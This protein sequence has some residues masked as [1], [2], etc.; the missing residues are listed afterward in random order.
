LSSVYLNYPGKHRPPM[1]T[2]LLGIRYNY[3]QFHSHR[4]PFPPSLVDS[5]FSLYDVS[6]DAPARPLVGRAVVRLR[7]LELED[8]PCVADLIGDSFRIGSAFGS[9][10]RPLFK[11]GLREDLRSR[12]QDRD[13]QK[14]L[15]LVACLS[16][17]PYP[18]I[19]TV[20]VSTRDLSSAQGGTKRYAY[21]ANL[22]VDRE[23]RCLGIGQQLVQ[24]CAA[25]AQSWG[26]HY[27]YLHVM[28]NNGAANRLYYRLGFESVSS[29]RPWHWLPWKRETR[30]FL[31]KPLA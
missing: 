7:P 23:Y 27:T 4:P 5:S 2:D 28:A 24:Q 21:I 31:R 25:V 22:A 29:D 20:E 15:C 19:G 26:F 10:L 16:H 1:P 6:F 9:W 14:S 11:L 3:Q 17:S 13:P 18:I 8:V 30:L 12:C